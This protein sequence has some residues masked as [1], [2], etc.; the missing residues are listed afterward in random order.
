MELK[1]YTERAV[2]LLLVSDKR[3]GGKMPYLTKIGM[4]KRERERE[5]GRGE[6]SLQFTP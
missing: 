1:K 6:I 3:S 2:H 5:S 4:R